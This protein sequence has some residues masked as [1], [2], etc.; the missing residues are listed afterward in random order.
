MLSSIYYIRFI[1][2]TTPFIT[3]LFYCTNTQARANHTPVAFHERKTKSEDADVDI[4]PNIKSDVVGSTPDPDTKSKPEPKA[5]M[6]VGVLPEMSSAHVK[7]FLSR[8]LQEA[9]CPG[10]AVVCVDGRAGGDRCQDAC[11]GECCVGEY[12]GDTGPPYYYETEGPCTGFSGTLC[13]DA[14]QPPCSGTYA[15]YQANIDLVVQ[16]CDSDFSC[17]RASIGSVVQGCNSGF[18]CENANIGSVSYACNSLFGCASANI[19]MEDISNCCNT[20]DPYSGPGA[21]EGVTELPAE[22]IPPSTSTTT[23]TTTSTAGSTVSITFI[24]D[25]LPGIVDQNHLLTFHNSL[26]SKQ[27]DLDYSA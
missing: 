22:C 25:S 21:C 26:P 16:G 2:L 12:T 17:E 11:A 13:K 4:S 14:Y 8:G 15:C 3:V 20:F 7:G 9:T 6:D 27:I 1:V 18:A 5:E 23:T 19:P 24:L 10:E